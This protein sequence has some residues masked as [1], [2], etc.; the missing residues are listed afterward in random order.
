MEE[1]KCQANNEYLPSPGVS[2]KH[3]CKVPPH[4]F[5]SWWSIECWHNLRFTAWVIQSS[6]KDWLHC[7]GIRNCSKPF[8][9]VF[10]N[11]VVQDSAV[12]HL[13]NIIF[14]KNINDYIRT[15]KYKIAFTWGIFLQKFFLGQSQFQIIKLQFQWIKDVFRMKITFLMIKLCFLTELSEVFLII[16]FQ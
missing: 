11:I 15:F 1:N 5:H 2:L 4:W 12:D 13:L 14:C 6:T 16:H 9:S 7:L 8:R 3:E 10:F